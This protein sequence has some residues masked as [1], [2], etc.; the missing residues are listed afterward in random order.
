MKRSGRH[1]EALPDECTRRDVARF[2]ARGRAISPP[3]AQP[4]PKHLAQGY[5]AAGCPLYEGY[6]LTESSP[7]I[8]FNYPGHHKIGSVGLPIPGVEV[9]IAADG[10]ILTRGPHVMKGYW[11]DEAATRATI[12]DGWLHTGDVGTIDDMDIYSSLIVKKI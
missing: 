10:E 2:S 4:L 7:V 5:I 1:V 12:V 8:S 9:K 6:G 3:A 11:K